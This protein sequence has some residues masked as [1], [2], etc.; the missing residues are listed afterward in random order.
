[1]WERVQAKAQTTPA[2]SVA[3]Q[4]DGK[5]RARGL[6]WGEP[7]L[8]EV[9]TAGLVLRG[10]GGDWAVDASENLCQNSL[11]GRDKNPKKG[12]SQGSGYEGRREKECWGENRVQKGTIFKRKLSF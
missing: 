4:G 6:M 7:S 8:Q 10:R 2:F 9:A 12:G 11:R 3:H 5:D 1:M